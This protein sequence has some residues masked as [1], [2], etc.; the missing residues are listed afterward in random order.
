MGGGGEVKLERRVCNYV[1]M[2][3]MWLELG[4][5]VEPC[6]CI[7]IIYETNLEENK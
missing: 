7:D 5:V 4:N 2:F 1:Y 6:T 3:F